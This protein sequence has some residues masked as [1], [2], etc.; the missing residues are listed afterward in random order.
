VSFAP[1]AG[2]L[3]LAGTLLVGVGLVTVLRI[4][5]A[6]R[7][8][9]VAPADAIVVFGAA[10]WPSGPSPTLRRRTEHAAALYG[11]GL[12]PL[13]VLS[14]GGAGRSSEPAAMAEVMRALGVPASALL[15]DETGVTT[16]ATLQAAARMGA[17]RWRRILAVSSPSHLFRIVEEARRQGIEALPCPARRAPAGD[18]AA[19]VRLLLFDARQYARE[20][21]AVWKYRLTARRGGTSSS[22]ARTALRRARRELSD[23]WRAFA[24]GAD[25]V[26]RTSIAIWSAIR[27]AA[28]PAER[29]PASLPRLRWP[30]AGRVSSAFGMRHGRLHEG[31]DI[32]QAL[33][34]PV[35]CALPG[36]VLLAGEMPGYGKIVVLDHA[37]QLATVYAH[38]ATIDVATGE[39]V[40][41]ERRVGTVGT[42]GH[43]T[44]PHL[45]FEVRFDGTAVDPAVLLGTD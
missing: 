29:T 5:R 2:A 42:T 16:R 40:D 21:A 8:T 45:H 28:G 3:G 36:T 11:R 32:A 22:R 14:G 7:T 17:G 15:L 38:L 18:R 12:A 9:R 30:V 10:V 25:E 43:T 41:L 1:L 24:G 31:I 33:G 20:V 23:R 6:A 44:G 39:G 27:S 4:L 19:R 34:T 35:R 13:V 37:Q 26:R